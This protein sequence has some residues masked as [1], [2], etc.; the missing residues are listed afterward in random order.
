MA[1]SAVQYP[2]QHRIQQDVVVK[3]VWYAAVLPIVVQKVLILIQVAAAAFVRWAHIMIKA[4]IHVNLIVQTLVLTL[5]GLYVHRSFV[6]QTSIV[7]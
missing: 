2:L 4:T 5:M 7:M 6:A 3:M 1:K